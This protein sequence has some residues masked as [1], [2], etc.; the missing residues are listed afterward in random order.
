MSICSRFLLG[1]FVDQATL[2][3]T[4]A[5]ANF[6]VTNL[7][8]ELRTKAWRSTG[9]ADQEVYIDFGKVRE[10]NSLAI[11]NH[12]LT[13][14]GAF[15]IKAGSS[16][17]AD[18]IMSAQYQAWETL[19]G[20]G[21]GGYGEH[22]F[23]GF[24][25]E[26]E[27]AIYF[28]AGPMRVIYFDP[29]SA[30]YWTIGFSNPSNNDGYLQ[31]GR[32]IL[33]RYRQSSRMIAIGAGATPQDPSK[34]SYSKGGQPWRDAR[35]KYREVSHRYEYIPANQ[36]YGLFYEMLQRVGVGVSFVADLFHGDTM[37][38]R[39]LQNQLYCHLPE[40]G[41]PPLEQDVANLGHVEL[42]L[43]ETR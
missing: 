42:S 36:T 23:G 22:G 40:G 39:R 24:L 32:L 33:D 21:E 9:L 13:A 34:V 20:W 31:V 19:F 17:G 28:P 27:I 7:Q 3:A 38:G 35:T 41:V 18:D 10:M 26:E 16:A 8:N 43:R 14:E 1:S 2:S 37:V 12:N 29:A 15:T 5:E 4:S 11:I 30:R 6:P 25:T